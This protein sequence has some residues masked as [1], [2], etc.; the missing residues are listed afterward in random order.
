LTGAKFFSAPLCS[1]QR[2]TAI[3]LR[4][5]NAVPNRIAHELRELATKCARLASYT[6]D[7][8]IANE[9]EGIGAELMDKAQALDQLFKLS[10]PH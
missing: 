8:D 4:K 6:T 1:K 10:E 5:E 2:A 3:V 7:K 9:L